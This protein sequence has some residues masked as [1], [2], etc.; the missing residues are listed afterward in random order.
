MKRA[1]LKGDESTLIVSIPKDG[2]DL[3]DKHFSDSHHI[4]SIYF[5]NEDE[6]MESFDFQQDEH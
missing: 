2:N 1:K 5:D 6:Y 3:V 4:K